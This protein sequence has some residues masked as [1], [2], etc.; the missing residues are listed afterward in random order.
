MLFIT[1]DGARVIAEPVKHMINL[2][3]ATETV[4]VTPIFKKG[5]RS[6]SRSW[7]VCLASSQFT[8]YTKTK[9]SNG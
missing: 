7:S 6:R 8:D 2:S 4:R 9:E 3:I 5:P 1:R